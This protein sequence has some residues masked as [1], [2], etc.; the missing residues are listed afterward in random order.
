M[1]AIEEKVVGFLG[2]ALGFRVR[3]GILEFRVGF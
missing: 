1:G 2:L 3:H